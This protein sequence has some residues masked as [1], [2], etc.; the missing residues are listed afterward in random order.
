MKTRIEVS[1]RKEAK[2]ISAGIRDPQTRAL[3]KVMGALA[4]LPTERAER[5]MMRYVQDHFAEQ[6][7]EI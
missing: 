4:M 1:D 3:V 5:R 7:E 6:D 2:L